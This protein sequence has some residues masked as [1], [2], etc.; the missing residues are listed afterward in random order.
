MK[1]PLPSVK[2]ACAT[3]EQE[4][5]QRL[6]LVPKPTEIMDMYNKNTPDRTMSCNTCGVKGHSSERCWKN[7]GYPRWHPKHGLPTTT[8]SPFPKKSQSTSAQPRWS[9]IPRPINTKIVANAQLNSNAS[10]Y[11]TPQQLEQLAKLMPQLHM[12]ESNTSKTDEELDYH[13]SRMISRSSS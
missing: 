12:G 1:N 5:A 7:I 6:L 2:T 11:F 8:K 9:S 10:Q 13:F 4:E 3:I